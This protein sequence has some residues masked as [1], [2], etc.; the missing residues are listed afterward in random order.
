MRDNDSRESM[1][2]APVRERSLLPAGLELGLFC[3][4]S[5]GCGIFGGGA[6]SGLLWGNG[7]PIPGWHGIGDTLR[8]LVREPGDPAAAWPADPRPGPAWLTW[9]C[10]V[11]VTLLVAS[12]AAMARAEFDARRRHR[13][14]RSGLATGSDLRRAG[15]DARSAS[16]KAANEFPTLAA[17]SKR[18]LAPRGR[19]RK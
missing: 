11:T 9:M 1:P 5:L 7:I 4:W 16:D 14:N 13:R 10:I 17:R 3:A 12:A 8:G 15:L 19:W 2:L 6:V 18:T